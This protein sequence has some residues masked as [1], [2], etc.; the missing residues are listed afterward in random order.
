MKIK[1]EWNF[2]ALCILVGL[3]F[4]IGFGFLLGLIVENTLFGIIAGIINGLTFA[5]ICYYQFKRY[6]Q[7][8]K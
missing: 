7:Y 2:L 3:V 6:N 5:L 1:D 8:K 4:G